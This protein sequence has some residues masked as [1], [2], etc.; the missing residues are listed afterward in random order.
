MSLA[1]RLDWIS[2]IIPER[3]SVNTDGFCNNPIASQ[4]F[5]I[6]SKFISLSECAFSS[7]PGGIWTHTFGPMNAGP[8]AEAVCHHIPCWHWCKQARMS[9]RTFQSSKYGSKCCNVGKR[10]KM[11]CMQQVPTGSDEL[12]VQRFVSVQDIEE[13]LPQITT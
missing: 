1:V 9:S 5:S 7:C 11:I 6:H 10:G 13:T 8:T 4:L 2:D 12:R 3:A